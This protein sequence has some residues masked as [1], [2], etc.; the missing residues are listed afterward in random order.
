MLSVLASLSFHQ[1]TLIITDI[2][3]ALVGRIYIFVILENMPSSSHT[4]FFLGFIIPSSRH[5]SFQI[6]FTRGKRNGRK[7]LQRCGIEAC[8]WTVRCW[9]TYRRWQSKA[10]Y[11]KEYL[12]YRSDN[13]PIVYTLIYIIVMVLVTA[14]HCP[15]SQWPKKTKHHPELGRLRG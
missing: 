7:I 10:V 9:N 8:I 2:V 13:G 3:M 6:S 4:V 1:V 11:S 15:Q 5:R 12:I 14:M